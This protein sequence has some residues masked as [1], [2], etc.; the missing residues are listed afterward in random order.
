[1]LSS[2]EIPSLY[3]FP[4]P[5]YSW[6]Q[7]IEIGGAQEITKKVIIRLFVLMCLSSRLGN[8]SYLLEQFLPVCEV[9][10]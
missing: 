3:A 6:V 10:L 8:L 5:Q 2:G 7:G 4:A 9:K 1:M